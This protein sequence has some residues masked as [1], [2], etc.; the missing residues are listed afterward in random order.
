MISAMSRRPFTGVDTAA[1]ESPFRRRMVTWDLESARLKQL[2]AD[3]EFDI[4]LLDLIDERFAVLRRGRETFATVS[5]EFSETGFRVGSEKTISRFS[6]SYMRL[7]RRAWKRLVRLLKEANKLDSVRVGRVYWATKMADGS[8][9]PPA[10]GAVA[11]L[12]RVNRYF[13]EMYAWMAR[14]LQPGQFYDYTESELTLDPNHKWGV[15]VYHYPPSY[16]ERLRARLISERELLQED[17][18][19]ADEA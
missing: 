7:W 11:G 9:P 18:L 12:K 3:G 8:A 16:N 13:D 10:V 17:R 19:G 15:A 4:L 6:K 5:P 14:D 2:I 1:I